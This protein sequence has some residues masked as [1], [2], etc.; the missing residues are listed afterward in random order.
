VAGR[1][2]EKKKKVSVAERFGKAKVVRRELRG[3]GGEGRGDVR[4]SYSGTRE[5]KREKVRL[6]ERE[7]K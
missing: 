4:I 2:K 3:K 1:G 5:R 7:V 6:A